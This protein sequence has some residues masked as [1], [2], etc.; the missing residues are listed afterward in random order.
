MGYSLDELCGMRAVHLIAPDDRALARARFAEAVGGLS[1]DYEAA[2]HTSNGRLLEMHLSMVPIFAEGT[3][4]G[5]YAVAKDTTLRRRLLDLTR[6]ISSTDSVGEQVR[7][8]LRAMR[9]VLWY[10]SGGLYLADQQ[11]GDP[12]SD[13]AGRGELGLGRAR[14]VPH[15]ARPGVMGSVAQANVGELVN[16]AHLDP[17]GS[18]R[19]AP[20]STASTWSWCPSPS[21][22]APSACS[23]W[24]GAPIRRSPS[25]SSRS[26]NCSS[27][28]PPRPS[29]RCTC[30]NR[31]ALP[32]SVSITRRCTIRSPICRTACSCTIG[33]ARRSP[34]A[35]ARPSRSP[36][37]YS[38]WTASRKSTTRSATRPATDCCRR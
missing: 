21:R 26:C 25:A 29:P 34:P 37:S 28:T 2:A 35:V 3:V 27:A 22:A 4:V 14:Q 30:S 23:T 32:R 10:D 36:C 19:R 17:R 38:I 5:V 1:Q 8:I 24:R 18:T 6:P 11:A 9:D 31:R 13:R 7:V 16:N 20:S 33:S 15:S 12:A